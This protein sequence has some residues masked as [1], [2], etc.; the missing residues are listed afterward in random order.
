MKQQTID[1]YEGTNRELYAELRKGIALESKQLKLL[2]A[3]EKKVSTLVDRETRAIKRERL[4]EKKKTLSRKVKAYREE[5]REAGLDSRKARSEIL[6]AGETLAALERE[7]RASLSEKEAFEDR[8]RKKLSELVASRKAFQAGLLERAKALKKSIASLEQEKASLGEE[9][10]LARR[11]VSKPGLAEQLKE[12]KG[13]VSRGLSKLEHQKESLKG[14]TLAEKREHSNT[15][16]QLAGLETELTGLEERKNELTRAMNRCSELSKQS[17]RLSSE[18]NSVEENIFKQTQHIQDLESALSGLGERGKGMPRLRA[19]QGTASKSIK[20][21][22]K[23]YV[24]VELRLQKAK[25]SFTYRKGLL[26]KKKHVIAGGIRKFEKERGELL[27]SLNSDKEQLNALKRKTGAMEAAMQREEEETTALAQKAS[28]EIEAVQKSMLVGRA[29]LEKLESALKKLEGAS[30]LWPGL[31][32]NVKRDRAKVM[33]T[34]AT[35]QK[36]VAKKSGQLK[37]AKSVL[38]GHEESFEEKK[39]ELER[40]HSQK[41]NDLHAHEAELSRLS[42]TL[43]SLQEELSET[44]HE[45]AKMDNAEKARVVELQR[46][47]AEKTNKLNAEI[48]KSNKARDRVIEEAEALKAEHRNVQE[49]T[50]KAYKS[51]TSSVYDCD[52][53]EQRM[54]TARAELESCSVE[55]KTLDAVIERI[56]LEKQKLA[57]VKRAHKDYETALERAEE[58]VMEGV[59]SFAAQLRQKIRETGEKRLSELNHRI[60]SAG[61]LR[62]DALKSV[63]SSEKELERALKKAKESIKE[64]KK[65]ILE[66]GGELRNAQRLEKSKKASESR[67]S[68]NLLERKEWLKNRI[69]GLEEGLKQVGDQFSEREQNAAELE[70]ISREMTKRAKDREAL[71]IESRLLHEMVS[72]LRTGK[73]ADELALLFQP[74]TEERME[75]AYLLKRV[76]ELLGNLPQEEITKFSKSPDFRLYKKLLAKYRVQ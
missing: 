24:D 76:D 52:E 56:D 37:E 73:T 33:E 68:E 42:K 44:R 16:K 7:S 13:L 4:A 71:R 66:R 3:R 38:S 53:L 45:S 14:L 31:S 43:S 15:K 70:R 64:K 59:R 57:T 46:S 67:H 49:E 1:L 30:L 26:S 58:R 21:A 74:R 72:K 2:E 8:T 55:E 23:K 22:R 9:F 47:L 75:M 69:A 63:A 60:A 10:A 50:R 41:M 65:E 40:L 17:S 28:R 62:N 5:L 12:F 39:R 25:E 51:L 6:K 36:K 29:R 54:E 20:R 35:Q 32:D 18:K 19:V 27:E 48:E 61:A 34:L 11:A